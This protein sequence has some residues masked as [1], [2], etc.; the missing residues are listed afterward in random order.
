MSLF[1]RCGVVAVLSIA[2]TLLT[3][4]S[5]RQ[6]PLQPHVESEFGPDAAAAPM[7]GEPTVLRPDMFRGFFPLEV[8]N[9]WSYRGRVSERFIPIQGDPST[10]VSD[11]RARLSLDCREVSEDR[12]YVV[13]TEVVEGDNP[14]TSWLRYR[15]DREGLYEAD[16]LFGPCDRP[17]AVVQAE[18]RPVLK[19]EALSNIEPRLRPSF[20]AAYQRLLARVEMFRNLGRAAARGVNAPEA[21]GPN[22]ITRLAYPLFVGQRWVIRTDPLFTSRVLALEILPL[23]A[24][25]LSGF[26]VQIDSELFG[27]GNQ[28]IFWVSRVGF[29]AYDF[30]TVLDV[31]DDQGNFLGQIVYHERRELVDFQLHRPGG[32]RGV[33]NPERVT[34]TVE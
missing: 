7:D 10:T 22:E 28:F 26:K 27:P 2:A 34:V 12:S 3:G 13:Q 19:P 31:T 4:C 5:S 25:R 14:Y 11:Y 17:E 30:Q 29:L 32:G 16:N 23:P 18:R 21:V 9:H 33:A 24:G 20:A 1:L 15:Q 8:G 6:A